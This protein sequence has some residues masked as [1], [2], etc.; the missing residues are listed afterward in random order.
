MVYVL[1]QTDPLPVEPYLTTDE[2][3]QAPT[4]V[5]STG[6]V[7]GDQ[8][9]SLAE[10][11][12][13]IARASSWADTM[14]GQVLAATPDVEGG[15]LNIG[16]DGFLRIHP[17]QTPILDVTGISYGTIPGQMTALTDLSNVWV[18]PAMII[19]PLSQVSTIFSGPLAFTRIVP[20]TEVYA[21]WQYIAGWPNTTLTGAV[22]QGATSLSVKTPTGVM[23]GAQL[24]IY[25]GAQT[26]TVTVS[27]T[28]VPM[29]TP[30]TL[31]SG[32]LWAHPRLGISVSG[33]PPGVK[34]AVILLT[35]ALIKT[36]GA[37]SMV[38][39]SVRGEMSRADTKAEAG[40][41][42]EIDLADELL[43]PYRR[44]R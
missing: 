13:V 29:T 21:Q 37:S 2:Y 32:T 22:T 27:S 7:K 12:N 11:G 6:L 23:P 38:M 42:E 39:Q 5:D 4:G 20:S 30:V 25:D 36:R 24:T 44:L 16:R 14:C 15:R 31:G 33:L 28:Y 41:V 19:V 18:E 1:T 10:L 43:A 17:R 9:A 8:A 3:R 34:Q 35:S 26:E 40:G